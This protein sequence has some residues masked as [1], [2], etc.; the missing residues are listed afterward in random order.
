MRKKVPEFKTE[1]RISLNYKIKINL[2]VS[3]SKVYT[4]F[5]TIKS[6]LKI[7]SKKKKKKKKKKK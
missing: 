6:T 1:E 3:S 2:A 7:E 5:V 4:C